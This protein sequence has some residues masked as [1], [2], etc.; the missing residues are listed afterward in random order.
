MARETVEKRRERL[1]GLIDD[2]NVRT[3][4]DLIAASEGVAHGYNTGFGNTVLDALEQDIER[5]EKQCKTDPET[6]EVI[7][8]IR[9]NV[10]ERYN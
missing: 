2:P 6:N 9:S 5:V 3:M 8:D 7:K 4:L 1:L 10:N